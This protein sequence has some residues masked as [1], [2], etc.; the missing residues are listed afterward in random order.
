MS[1][2]NLVSVMM[3]AYNAGEYLQA[4]VQSLVDQ[5]HLVWEL[6]IVDDGSVDETPE[7]IARLNDPRIRTFSQENQGEASARNAALSLATGEYLAF[8][9]ADDAFLPQHLEVTVDYL[10]A[11]PEIGG[12]YTDGYY[13]D[14]A[15]EVL[16]RLSDYRRG[17]FEGWIFEELTRASDV[18][19]PPLCVVLRMEQVRELDLSFDT[20][21]TIGPDWDFLSS[22]A[23]H[24]YFAYLNLK[25]CHYRIHAANISITTGNTRRR[26]SLALCRKKAIKRRAFKECSINTRSYVFYELLVELLSGEP[27]QQSEIV[28]WPE[29]EDLPSVEQARILRLMAGCAVQ[30]GLDE[31]LVRSWFDLAARRNPSDFR[32]RLL[33]YLF[34]ISP[35][36]SKGLLAFR[37]AVRPKHKAHMPFA[38][39]E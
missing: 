2:E 28:S 39:L 3:P 37:S 24:H 36:L 21:I 9:D 15:G 34:R 18:F 1:Q 35:P 29:F 31:G 20:Q 4:A 11:H 12:V 14:G 27:E 22:Y 13:V 19:G 23:E 10:C 5:T 6:I 33:A 8:L 7:I 30:I 25:T 17:P 32:N 38:S 26:H 16:G